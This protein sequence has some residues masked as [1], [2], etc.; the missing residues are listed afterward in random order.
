MV[1]VVSSANLENSIS[2]VKYQLSGEKGHGF[3]I[4]GN[5]PLDVIKEAAYRAIEKKKKNRSPSQQVT[6]QM[7][8]LGQ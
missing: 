7:W 6:F 8:K 5:I 2:R 3:N 1:E 4:C